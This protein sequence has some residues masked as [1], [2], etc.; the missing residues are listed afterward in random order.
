MK[1]LITGIVCIDEFK[2]IDNDRVAIYEVMQ[3][4]TIT[5]AKAEIKCS[6]NGTCFV[7][8]AASPIYRDYTRYQSFAKKLASQTPYR[9]APIFF[10]MLDE[11]VPD[12]LIRRIA[13]RVKN[14]IGSKAARTLCIF[15]T[16]NYN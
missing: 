16:K 4:Q 14:F 12:A 15:F 13:E 11:K 5:I 9:N 1:N 10:F 6:L 3:Q 7:I 2:M 8:E